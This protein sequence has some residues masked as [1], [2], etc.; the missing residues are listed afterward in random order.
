MH[1]ALELFVGNGFDGTSIRDIATRAEVNV[2][3]VNYYLGQRTNCSNRL[4]RTKQV[5]LKAYSKN[6]QAIPNCQKWKM[7]KIIDIYVNRFLST[8]GLS[9]GI[10]PGTAKIRTWF[11]SPADHKAYFQGTRKSSEHH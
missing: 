4:L 11:T 5:T 3:M 9:Q 6:L 7:E 10:V 2:A 8:T 1:H